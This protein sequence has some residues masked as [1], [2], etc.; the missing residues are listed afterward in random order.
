[1]SLPKIVCPHNKT[2]LR[3]L[4]GYTVAVKVTGLHH[5]QKAARHVRES[6]NNLLCV[7]VESDSPLSDLDLW[8]NLKGTPLAIMAPSLGK[9][10]NLAKGL[11]LLRDLDLRVYLPCNHPDNIVALRI[12]S[13]VGIHSCAVFGDGG[14]DWDALTDLMTY[15]VLERVPHASIEPFAFIASNYDP[16]AYLEWGSIWFDDPRHFLHLDATGRVALYRGDLK[17]RKFI[18][19]DLSKIEEDAEFPA[20]RERTNRWRRLLAENHHCA[21]CV[22]WKACLG[23]F[24]PN[25]P[26]NNGCSAFFRE[27]LETACQNRA[28]KLQNEESRVWQP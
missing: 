2:L 11:N 6:G 14:T 5:A 12:L 10:R 4:Q 21:S 23:R 24:A 20:I 9:F 16:S 3:S 22:G 28:R 26:G 17:A 19:H 1:M 15:A 7:M 13:S 25:K 8:E 18:A 27:M